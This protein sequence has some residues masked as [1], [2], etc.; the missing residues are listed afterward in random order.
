MK[1]LIANLSLLTVLV[2]TPQLATAQG[3]FDDVCRDVSADTAQGSEI[4]E[5]CEQKDT[6]SNPLVGP[7]GT[8]L[9][10]ADIL[11]FALGIIS[12]IMIIIG[13]IKYITSG[14]DS[15]KTGSARNTILYA[16]IGLVVA[17][18]A[19]PLIA[20]IIRGL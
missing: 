4:P 19:R 9:K 20:F 5:V 7:N 15:G 16:I 1:K 14:G 18:L 2:L 13:G 11:L 3:V 10:V 8:L 17:A 6:T 12:V